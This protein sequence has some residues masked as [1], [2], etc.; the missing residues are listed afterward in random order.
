M[1]YIIIWPLIQHN[2]NGKRHYKKKYLPAVFVLIS[3]EFS[4]HFTLKKKG[5]IK[6]VHPFTV[7]IMT[8]LKC[9]TI[10]IIEVCFTK[11]TRPIL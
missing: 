1:A 2:G 4:T 9:Y 6:Y 8:I 5:L 11:G 7:T 10:I 3:T